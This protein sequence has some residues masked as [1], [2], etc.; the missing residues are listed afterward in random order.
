MSKNVLIIAVHP[1]DETI[2]CGGTIFHHLAKGDNVFC[3]F[4]TSG[5]PKQASLISKVSTHYGFNDTFQLELPEIILDSLPLKDIIG[6]LSKVIQKVRPEIV[7]IPNRSDTHSDHRATFNACQACLKSFRYP[8]VEKVLM[9]E[10]ISETDFAPALP[11]NYFQPN[12][13]VDISAFMDK[14]LE[15]LILFEDELLPYPCTRNV[16]AMNALNRYRGSLIN[17]EYAEAFVLLKEI[18]R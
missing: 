10:V 8:F 7:Y 15:A 4:V 6:P 3:V 11:E 16:E 2:G 12:T 17:A 9:I 14:K 5:N 1:D 18:I 13:F